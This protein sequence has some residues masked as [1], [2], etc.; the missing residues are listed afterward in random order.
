MHMMV[1]AIIIA[2][3]LVTDGIVP[4]TETAAR[5]ATLTSPMARRGARKARST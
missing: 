2:S 4:K 3:S 1:C 5:G